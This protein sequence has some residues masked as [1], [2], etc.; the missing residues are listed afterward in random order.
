MNVFP[1]IDAGRTPPLAGR[2]A[3]IGGVFPDNPSRNGRKIN[4]VFGAHP[5]AGSAAR[6]FV[7]VNDRQTFG[8]HADGI[9]GTGPGARPQAQAADGAHFHAAAE[10]CHRPAIIQTVI[11]I[12]RIRIFDPEITARQGDIR[13]KSFDLNA[14]NS[15]NGFGHFLTGGHTGIG[16]RCTGNDS[17]CVRAA[18]RQPAPASVGTRQLFFDRQN[19]GIN[20]NVKNLGCDG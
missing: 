7:F 18:T 16:G 12:F 1:N 17:L 5:L 13:F 19:L 9:K 11:H 3:F 8:T 15:G 6:A 10:Q 4:Y 14:H 20:I 2:R